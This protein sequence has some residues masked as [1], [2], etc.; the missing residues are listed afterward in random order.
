MD[1]QSFPVLAVRCEHLTGTFPPRKH[2]M[3][4]W[5][6]WVAVKMHTYRYTYVHL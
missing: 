3:V 6:D 2:R 1:E 5:W 4:Q